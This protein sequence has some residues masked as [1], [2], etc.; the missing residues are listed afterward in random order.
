MFPLYIGS[1]HSVTVEDFVWQVVECEHCDLEW[2]LQQP[3][4]SA[5]M[6]P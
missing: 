1:R 5:R 3:P 4:R 6:A 2:V